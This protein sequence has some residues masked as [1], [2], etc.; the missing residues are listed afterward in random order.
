MQTCG[1]QSDDSLWCW[2]DSLV[3]DNTTNSRT[4]PVAIMA[5]TTF[6]MVEIGSYGRHTCAISI[7]G[8]MYC[9]GQDSSDQLGYGPTTGA[10][11]SP[12]LVLGGHKWKD[13]AMTNSATCGI[14]SDNTLWCWGS[15]QDGQLGTGATFNSAS[16]AIGDCGNPNK[17]AG[18]V[19]YNETSKS[20]AYCDG[21]G[22]VSIL[23]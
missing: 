14:K 6:K 23:K 18:A 21:V 5:G 2:G 13:V 16:A 17:P 7:A 8:D 12:Q 10:K 3:G 1:I 19:I 4:S 9:W 15:N 22:W 11:R 20:V